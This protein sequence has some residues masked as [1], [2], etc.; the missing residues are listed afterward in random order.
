MPVEEEEEIYTSINDA[1]ISDI[2]PKQNGIRTQ[3]GDHSA[4]EYVGLPPTGN[5]VV[6]RDSDIKDEYDYIDGDVPRKNDDYLQPSGNTRP[7]SDRPNTYLQLSEQTRPVSNS[8]DDYLQPSGDMRP[9]SDLSG[10]YLPMSE[11]MGP[12]SES[13]DDYVQPSGDMRPMS[14]GSHGGD[15][16]SA[17]GHMVHLSDIDYDVPRRM[18]NDSTDERFDFTTLT[19]QQYP[20]GYDFTQSA[21]DSVELPAAGDLG[22]AYT[23]QPYT[24]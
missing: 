7:A 24:G 3:K 8:N 15:Y 18:H 22:V 5:G 12:L 17:S 2:A 19:R 20:G 4:G 6:Q 9:V 10:D 1:T 14:P 23:P 13:T 16:L 21:S 11:N